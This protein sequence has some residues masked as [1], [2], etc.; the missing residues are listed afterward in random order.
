MAATYDDGTN[1]YVVEGEEKV[2]IRRPVFYAL[3]QNSWP[4]LSMEQLGATI[5][6]LFITVVDEDKSAE[7]RR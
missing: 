3:A 5:E 6:D 1:S 7:A 2:D 4:I